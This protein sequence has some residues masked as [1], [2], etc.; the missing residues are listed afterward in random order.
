[1]VYQIYWKTRNNTLFDIE[2]YLEEFNGWS[3]HLDTESKWMVE[4]HSHS[5]ISGAVDFIKNND[6]DLEE[7]K[8]DCDELEELRRWLWE[9]HSNPPRTLKE[10][11]KDK[12][13]WVKHIEDKITPF[14]EK[15]GLMINRD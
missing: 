5:F 11:H 15:Y 9:T 1:M 14:A 8:K 7:F 13:E 10:A 3:P 4:M 2:I 12:G 6:I